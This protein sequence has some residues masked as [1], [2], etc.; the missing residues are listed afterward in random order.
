ME[1]IW[2]VKIKGKTHYRVI[3]SDTTKHAE[4]FADG[5]Y[6]KGEVEFVQ[7]VSKELQADEY[8]AY[9]PVERFDIR[10]SMF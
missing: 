1:T 6:Y 5:W 7:C 2:K 8:H 10:D 4:G 9:V 3:E